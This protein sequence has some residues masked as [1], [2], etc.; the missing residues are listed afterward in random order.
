MYFQASFN[1]LK[2]R[3]NEWSINY[4]DID[5]HRKYSLSTLSD[6]ICVSFYYFL[7]LFPVD[8]RQLCGP[9]VFVIRAVV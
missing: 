8:Q 9:S 4:K 5:L 1:P 7:F 6:I 3:Q 2:T